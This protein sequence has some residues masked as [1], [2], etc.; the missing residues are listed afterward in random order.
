MLID[1]L[2]GLA[3]PVSLAVLD[4]AAPGQ[5]QHDQAEHEEQKPPTKIDVDVK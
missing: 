2:L 1:G 3:S 5:K 4:F